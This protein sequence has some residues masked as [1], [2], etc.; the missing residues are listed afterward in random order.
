LGL[1]LVLRKSIL[2]RAFDTPDDTRVVACK[3]AD[4]CAHK[5]SVENFEDG[6]VKKTDTITGFPE[7]F[8]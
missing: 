3:I 4:R 6:S 8:A 1:Q 7:M 2:P 5:I